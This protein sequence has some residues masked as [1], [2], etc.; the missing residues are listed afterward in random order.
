MHD[1]E[2]AK[3][4]SGGIPKV[5]VMVLVF[6]MLT[7]LFETSP[8]ST[9]PA[10]PV[11][12]AP[13]ISNVQHSTPTSSSVYITWNTDQSDSD[14]RVKYYS[15]DASF[16]D[17]TTVKLGQGT[18]P[19]S[20]IWENPIYKNTNYGSDTKLQIG[21]SDW[22]YA[23]RGIIRFDLSSLP[24]GSTITDAKLYLYF[25]TIPTTCTLYAHRVDHDTPDYETLWT[26]AGVT[27]NKYDGTN[28]WGAAGGNYNATATDS[29]TLSTTGWYNLDVTS[30]CDALEERS[31]ILRAYTADMYS[32]PL[33]YSKEY[34][35]DT[36]KRP[37]L[38]VTYTTQEMPEQWSDWHNN[39]DSVNISLT[40]LNPNTTYYY[41]AWS[42]NGT[43]PAYYSYSPIYNFTTATIGNTP[44][45]TNVFVDLGSGNSVTFS[46]VIE[47]G[48]TS[49]NVTEIN[50]WGPLP[51][52]FNVAGDFHDITT[53]ASYSGVVAVSL[54]YNESKASNESNLKLF[55][56]NESTW[57]DVTYSLDTV[58]NVINGTV[59]RLSPFVVVEKVNRAPVLDPI[60]DKTVDEGQLLTFT[61]SATDPDGDV[62][63]YSATNLP[64]GADFDS[65]TQTFSW[66]P[67]YEQA[68]SYPGVHF[69]V[70]DGLLT[71]YEDIT[72]TVNDVDTI[73]PNVTI[74]TPTLGWYSAN[75]TVNATATDNVGVNTVR[76]RWENISAQ[77]IWQ[78]MI[79]QA[80]TDYWTA[81]FDISTVADGNYTIRVNATDNS[82]NEGTQTV[83]EIGIDTTP[84]II[85]NLQPTDGETVYQN[86]VTVCALLSDAG[87]GIDTETIVVKINGVELSY[88]INR[89][90]DSM[91][92][93]IISEKRWLTEGNH[94]ATINVS[95]KA[96]HTNQ[97]TW[98]FTVKATYYEIALELGWNLISLP[99]I[100]E[101]S[102]IEAVLEGVPNVVS[103][104]AYDAASETW[105]VYSSVDA[106][107]TLTEMKDGIGY[108]VMMDGSAY[109]VVRGVTM[110]P[111]AQVPPSYPVYEGWN[112]IGF[113]S[114]EEMPAEEYLASVWSLFEK[115]WTYPIGYDPGEGF[116]TTKYMAP[117]QGYWLYMAKDGVIIPPASQR[118]GVL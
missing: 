78:P 76:F 4:A 90:N 13:S 88:D 16:I 71:D 53:T 25:Y 73:P 20:Y 31:W 85:A 22:I 5:G 69:E 59:T 99:V 42:Y 43:D 55:H 89:T 11:A 66:T 62:L 94:S 7:A 105:Y 110:Y 61:I 83:A 14:N 23:S 37:Y 48:D 3:K 68:G 96:D 35:T 115:P 12:T 18:A 106:A 9:A 46:E 113:K 40:G 95:D 34:T 109:L 67:T 97:T 84:P 41:Q 24:A 116:Y 100:P 15:A 65:V 103:V 86:N 30:D 118:E 38:E 58:N 104:W 79:R 70:S 93:F 32:Y 44:T 17:T 47:S 36:T 51:D 50:L 77:G 60:G 1:S 57:E 112:L 114:T 87:S 92:V 102:S 49:D 72:I 80:G 26:E 75:F 39:T 33:V 111:G 27:W 81:T 52:G 82:T 2:I 19:D 117:G 108:W 64:A 10:P 74:N 98:S 63:T 6:I 45:G 28:N 8:V 91:E 56:W 21:N 29:T 54:T 107:N 101:N